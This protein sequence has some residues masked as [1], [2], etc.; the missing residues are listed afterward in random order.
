MNSWRYDLRTQETW[1]A[2]K[3]FHSLSTDDYETFCVNPL[4]I[5]WHRY[6]ELFAYGMTRFYLGEDVVPISR[7][8]ATET[9]TL[10]F[11]CGADKLFLDWDRENQRPIL[12][13]IFDD[14]TWAYSKSV[15]IGVCIEIKTCLLT[16][17]QH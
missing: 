14:L 17:S 2:C 4:K 15:S 8:T 3:G 11:N 13:G 10:G 1:V 16:Y 6:L 12:P 5:D 9:Y 7:R